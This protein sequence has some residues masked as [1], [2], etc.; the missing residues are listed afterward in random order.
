MRRTRRFRNGRRHRAREMAHGGAR[1]IE[2]IKGDLAG[3]F[4]R[5]RVVDDHAIG[6]IERVRHLGRQRCIGIH[7][8]ARA[9]RDVRLEEMHG[10]AGDG[11]RHLTQHGVVV[12]NVDTAAIGADDEVIALEDEIA[13]RRV[14]KIQLERLPVVAVVEAHEHSALGTGDEQSR[15][16]GV[17]THHARKAPTRLTD[18]QSVD[19]GHPRPSVIV[20]AIEARHVVAGP[21]RI[22]GDVC[23]TRVRV[24]RIDGCDGRLRGIRQAG[25]R[26]VVPRLSLVLCHLH[27]PVAGAHPDRAAR[28]GRCRHRFD[29][30]ALRCSGQRGRR[31]GGR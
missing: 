31:V 26:D 17:R 15:A 23:A 28:D 8:A 5:N 30:S 19:D 6:R 21:V 14:W 1:R 2:N 18:G 13:I 11:R 27:E 16:P 24:R 22:D 10:F 20:C 25:N 9:D 3:R 29:R 7:V 4:R 12:E